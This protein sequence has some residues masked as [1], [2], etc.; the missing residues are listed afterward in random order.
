MDETAVTIQG[1]PHWLYRAVDR[2]G[3]TV[4][5]LLRARRDVE[6]AQAFFRG[7]VARRDVSWPSKINLDGNSATHQSLRL[8]GEEDPRWKSVGARTNRYL[9]NL[10]EQDH[11]AVKQ[12]CAAMLGFKSFGTAATTLAGIELVHRIRKQQ[13]GLPLAGNQPRLSL[14]QL[15][16]CAL[17]SPSDPQMAV[18]GGT[19]PMH[20]NSAAVQPRTRFQRR[21]RYA[22]RHF[23]IKVPYGRSLYLLVTPNG[24]RYWRYRYS[25]R[26][27]Q[28]M[29]ALGVYPDVP[30]ARAR[31]RHENAKRLLSQ[32]IDPSTRK[33]GIRFGGRNPIGAGAYIR[34]TSEQN[35]PF[36]AA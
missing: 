28:K 24:G 17:R 10:I 2:D 11:R 3:K 22:R 31:A 32:D 1:V 16:E 15:W 36:R 27:K 23:P 7:A 25:F 19:P 21:R 4:H 6:S 29:L 30:V 34:C 13:F 35:N 5:S 33:K 9:N 14:R 18:E 26:G 20:Q 12:R 8:L